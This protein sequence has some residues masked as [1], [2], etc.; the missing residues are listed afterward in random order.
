L[1]EFGASGKMSSLKLL[2]MEKPPI[3]KVYRQIGSYEK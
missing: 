2:N 1:G 3:P